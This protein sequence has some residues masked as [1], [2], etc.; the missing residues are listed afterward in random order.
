VIRP[1]PLLAAL[2]A[3]L[4]VLTLAGLALEIPAADGGLPRINLLVGLMM[5]QAAAYFGAVAVTLRH[6]LPARTLWLVLGIGILL[7]AILLPTPPFLSSDIY[8]YVWDGRVQAAG[9][10]PYR[11]LP[12]DPA[13]TPLRDAQIY[14]SI[15][16]PDYAR[17]IYPPMAQLVFAAV[18]RVRDSVTAMKITM[19]GFEALGLLCMLPILAMAG[20]PRER[21]LIYAWNPLTLWSFASDGHVDA[22]A[23]G[24]LGV[25]LLLRARR[26]HGWAGALLGC[27]TLVK[28]FPIVIAPALLRGGRFWRAACAGTAVILALYGIYSSAGT[29]V[30]GFLPAYGTEEGLADGSGFWL[31]D[32]L[33]HLNTLPPGASA[34]YLA[35]AAL[36]LLGLALLVIRRRRPGHDAVVM[37]GDAAVLMAATMAAISPHYPWYFAWLALPCVVAPSRPV[38]WLATVPMLLTLDPWPDARFLW[39]GLLYLPAIALLCADLWPRRAPN[40]APEG[41]PPCPLPQP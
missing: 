4:L 14:P 40:A 3:L 29:H 22:I 2:G 6:R 9:I 28:F 39:R 23:V 25:T 15:N 11:Y 13:L 30:L 16:R 33:S 41:T 37:C 32:G 12:V 17:T 7:R 38:L 1:L 34:A 35:G 24:L 19:V 27:A 36:A 10:N 20:L 18:V 5:I 21:I 31:L 26:H 8:R